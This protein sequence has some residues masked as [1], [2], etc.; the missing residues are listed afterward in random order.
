MRLSVVV[1]LREKPG[2]MQRPSALKKLES[3]VQV[4]HWTV[5][6]RAT[7]G[8]PRCHFLKVQ[9]P[10]CSGHLGDLTPDD[11]ARPAYKPS[12]QGIDLGSSGLWWERRPCGPRRASRLA[13]A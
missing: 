5:R 4:L 9:F 1:A 6:V 11:Q 12:Y 8:K 2:G 10:D 13:R 7:G 3:S